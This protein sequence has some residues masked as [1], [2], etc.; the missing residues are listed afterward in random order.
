[1][2]STGTPDLVTPPVDWLAVAPSL[3][4]FAAAVVIAYEPG[5]FTAS[6]VKQSSF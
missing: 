2:T 3:A 5:V 4:L 6:A 1:M